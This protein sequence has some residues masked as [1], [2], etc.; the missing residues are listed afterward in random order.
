MKSIL[1]PLVALALVASSALAQLQIN[2]PASAVVCEPLLLTWSGGT[3]PYF[4]SILP[5][6]QPGASAL[7]TFPQTSATSVTWNVDIA[8]QTSLGLDIRDSSGAIAQSAPFSVQAGPS[9]S[10]VGSSSITFGTTATGAATAATSATGTS[11]TGTSPVTLTSASGTSPFTI[12]LTQSSS[13]GTGTASTASTTAK[14]TATRATAQVAAAG[15]IGAVM[16][17]LL[18]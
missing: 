18:G 14:S 17:A 13:T 16:V 3:P 6:N 12:G 2:T 1:A 7:I 10:C 9:S 4:L 11:A 8:A 5:G 15:I